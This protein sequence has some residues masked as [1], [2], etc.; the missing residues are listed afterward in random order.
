MLRTTLAL[1]LLLFVTSASAKAQQ[2]LSCSNSPG[3]K[4]CTLMNN[5]KKSYDGWCMGDACDRKWTRQLN[6][7]NELK[8]QLLATPYDENWAVDITVGIKAQEISR[9][10]CGNKIRAST[11]DKNTVNLIN[12]MLDSEQVLLPLLAE[13]QKRSKQVFVTTCRTYSK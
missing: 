6:A 12:S 1:S 2:L 10:I 11:R 13:L 3:L 4:V 9:A 7:I 8:A 5:V